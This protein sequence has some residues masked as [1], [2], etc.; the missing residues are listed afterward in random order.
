MADYRYG[1][2]IGTN[3]LAQ[4]NITYLLIEYTYI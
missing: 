2:I 1:D 3:I 4:L